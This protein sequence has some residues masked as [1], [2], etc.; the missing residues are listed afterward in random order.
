MVSLCISSAPKN[1]RPVQ[2][3]HVWPIL[4]LELSK[5]GYLLKASLSSVT[6]YSYCWVDSN[7]KIKINSTLDKDVR[8]SVF[9]AE[10]MCVQHLSF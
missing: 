9:S 8:Y 4:A 7:T 5:V 1:E 2:H 6:T 10:T 3:H